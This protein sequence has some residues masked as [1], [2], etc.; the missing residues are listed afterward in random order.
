MGTILD[1]IADRRRESVAEEKRT[2]DLELLEA[3]VA[4]VRPFFAAEGTTLIAECKQGSPSKGR[5]TMDYDPVATARAYERGGASAVSVLTEPEFFWGRDEDLVRVRAAVS[6]PVLRKDF[7]VDSWQIRHSRALGADAILLIA[8]LLSLQQMQEYAAEAASRG[9]SVLLEA[10]GEEELGM[11]LQVPTG[12]VGLNSRDLRDFSTDTGRL[13]R[14]A[15]LIPA[16]RIAVAESGMHDSSALEALY[17][18]GFRGFLVGEHFMTAPD[19][20]VAVAEFAATLARCRA[21]AV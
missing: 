1:R 4:P 18:A 8:G 15:G 5:L 6:L 3:R 7:I 14:W 16:D 11:I 2:V 20:E 17:R 9:L 10:H 21:G 19:P 13:A 12:A